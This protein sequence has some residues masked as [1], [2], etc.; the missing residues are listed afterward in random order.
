MSQFMD[1]GT[2]TSRPLA[3]THT[4]AASFSN[5][6]MRPTKT[7]R[8]CILTP[9]KYSTLSITHTFVE[10]HSYKSHADA[11]RTPPPPFLHGAMYQMADNLLSP[12]LHPHLVIHVPELPEQSLG[13]PQ[14]VDVRSAGPA[15]QAQLAEQQSAVLER[16]AGLLRRRRTAGRRRTAAGEG[17]SVQ[18]EG[19]SVQGERDS[20]GQYRGRG[21]QYRGSGTREVSTG[22][23]R[24]A[25]GHRTAARGG[26]V[27]T[28]GATLGRSV[29]GERHSGGQYRGRGGQYRT[30]AN[31]RRAQNRWKERSRSQGLYDY[32]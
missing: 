28:G 6:V 17:R 29:Q 10:F 9:N 7:I 27:S 21:G 4:P 8:P 13:L 11:G 15:R 18:G 25:G 23:W 5:A 12:P 26:E 24:T 1:T 19:R 31:G 3:Y 16:R 14:Q 20:G 2:V 32:M 22:R 30:L